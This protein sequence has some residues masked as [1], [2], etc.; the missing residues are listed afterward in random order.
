M[1]RDI[2]IQLWHCNFKSLFNQRDFRDLRGQVVEALRRSSRRLQ[3][4]VG[5]R[6]D[7]KQCLL[8]LLWLFVDWRLI[9]HLIG[10]LS[11]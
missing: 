1:V 5:D 4:D 3:Q 6:R 8:F 10:N 11:V 9:H 7:W 2:L